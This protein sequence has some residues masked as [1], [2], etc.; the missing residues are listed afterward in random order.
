MERTESISW[1]SVPGADE[2]A[3]GDTIGVAVP[4][5][6]L[7]VFSA[8]REATDVPLRCNFR[9]TRNTAVANVVA[10]YSAGVR[11]FDASVGGAG[12]RPFAPNA[13]GN[14]ATE[15]LLCLFDRMDVR[16]PIDPTET[17][18]TAR[19]FATRLGRELPGAVSRAGWWPLVKYPVSP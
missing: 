18:E 19:W 3:L 9:D 14:V 7:E 16:A 6:V 1:R 5:R 17:I 10:A 12:G 15:D 2:I 11:S 4:A 13:S 8:V